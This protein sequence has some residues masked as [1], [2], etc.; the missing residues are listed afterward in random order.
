MSTTI[1]YGLVGPKEKIIVF[2]SNFTC[3]FDR[4]SS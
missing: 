3:F 4:V 1:V 2:K